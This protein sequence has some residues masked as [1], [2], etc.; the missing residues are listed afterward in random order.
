MIHFRAQRFKL[1]AFLAFAIALPLIADIAATG[2]EHAATPHHPPVARIY[3]GDSL[4]GEVIERGP[5]LGEGNFGVVE[6]AVIRKPNGDTFPI[7]L[8]K[9]HPP[10]TSFTFDKTKQPEDI[11]MRWQLMQPAFA[12]DHEG[13]FT[14]GDAGLRY[15]PVG[16]PGA[17]QE[18]RVIVTE[19]ADG[20]VFSKLKSLKLNPSDIGYEAKLATIAKLHRQVLAGITL[21]STYGVSH[22]DIK[23]ENILYVTKP[24]F[25]WERPDPELIRFPLAD[26]DSVTPLRGQFVRFT[27]IYAPP[28]TF[29]RGRK[30]ATPAWDLY[31]ESLS[32][33][34]E[35]FGDHPFKQY[36]DSISG[37]PHPITYYK[38][39]LSKAY[40]D[41]SRYKEMLKYVDGRFKKLEAQ[42]K[43]PKA[44]L[45]LQSLHVSIVNGLAY[46]AE[47]RHKAFPEIHQG[48]LKYLHSVMN[49]H[50]RSECITN[51]V[52]QRLL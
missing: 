20:S 36:F 4:Y 19:L 9:L 49:G 1:L 29:A 16:N 28:E 11:E 18:A 32:A 5:I 31:S 38:Q 48:I 34:I 51:H 45:T 26:F 39:E 14:H 46:S 47:E 3:Q 35:I 17:E 24:G 15:V 42:T 52:R 8:K 27:P 10:Q 44:L 37:K 40:S 25:D 21:M 50:A 23:P 33:Y 2:S 41:P 30:N 13:V 6:K 7:A 22:G 12:N 43:S